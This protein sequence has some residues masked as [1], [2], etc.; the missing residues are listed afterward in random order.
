MNCFVLQTCQEQSYH[1]SHQKYGHQEVYERAIIASLSY[2]YMTVSQSCAMLS[3]QSSTFP[4]MVKATSNPDK[5]KLP[6]H[7]INQSIC[8]C[9]IVAHLSYL[10]MTV[11]Q[12]CAMLSVPSNKFPDMVRAISNPDNAK[13]LRTT[14]FPFG[15]RILPLLVVKPAATQ[16]VNGSVDGSCHKSLCI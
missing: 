16:Q 13:P 9:V 10:Y 8:R 2:L 14:S 3:V 5:A 7:C 15:S 11:S 1:K 12:S 4:D 6:T